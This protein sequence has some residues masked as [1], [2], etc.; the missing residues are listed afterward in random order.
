MGALHHI[1][2]SGRALYVGISNYSIEKTR[3][4]ARI[5]RELGTPCLM[6]QPI[7]N[8]FRRWAEDGLLNVLE[9]EGMGCIA[10]SPLAQG[11]LT[12][13]YLDG[14]PQGSRA[15]RPE[16]FLKPDQITDERRAQARAL[17]AIAQRRRQTLAQMALAWVLRHPGMTSAL[18]GASSV[19]QL[20]EN[21]NAL[22]GPPLSAEDIAE[23][24]KILKPQ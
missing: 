17:N 6:H 24:D 7:Y 4:A 8:M 11:M 9:E 23:I 3:D 22:N 10:F 20:E 2:R 18:I 19:A 1:I 5:L 13:R 12:A 14:I 15:A 16:S 21:L